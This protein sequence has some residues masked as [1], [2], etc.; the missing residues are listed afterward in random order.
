MTSSSSP[1]GATPA[2]TGTPLDT[3]HGRT[4]IADTVVATVARGAARDVAGVHGLGA[5]VGRAVGAIG[6]RITGGRTSSS[7]GISVEVG[8]RQTAIDLTVVVDYGAPL[9]AVARAIRQ[10]V[11][12]TVE[13]MTGLQVVEVN[14]EVADLHQPTPD[15]P[16]P[17]PAPDPSTRRVQ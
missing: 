15:T 9:A 5:G 1:A 16:G 10:N 14:I 13:R 12:T 4:T 7:A 11:I 6:Q 17:A 3:T 2:G 8:E